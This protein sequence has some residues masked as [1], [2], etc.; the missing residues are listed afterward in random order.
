MNWFFFSSRH[1]HINIGYEIQSFNIALLQCS[2][3]ECVTLALTHQFLIKPISFNKQNENERT[4]T[5]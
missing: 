5:N 1:R 4:K 3:I 2:H